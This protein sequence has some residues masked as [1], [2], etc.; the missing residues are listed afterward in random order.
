MSGS[1]TVYRVSVNFYPF[2]FEKGQVVGFYSSENLAST[3][4]KL[5]FL[6]FQGT[7]IPGGVDYSIDPVQVNWI[8]INEE[9]RIEDGYPSGRISTIETIFKPAEI[10]SSVQNLIRWAQATVRPK[11]TVLSDSEI[12]S[13]FNRAK[14][15]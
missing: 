10:T 2:E 12:S 3:V 15:V 11:I 7:D 14:V 6:L 4:Y 8:K 5:A 1:S 9:Y 13:I